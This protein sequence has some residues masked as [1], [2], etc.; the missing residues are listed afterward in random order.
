MD[1]DKRAVGPEHG[2]DAKTPAEAVLV[3]A[4]HGDDHGILPLHGAKQGRQQVDHQ[5]AVIMVSDGYWTWTMA[6]RPSAPAARKMG[7][8]S[9]AVQPLAK[10]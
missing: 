3:E 7:R 2:K 1:E 6:P 4:V 8:T 9:W 5:P 10:R